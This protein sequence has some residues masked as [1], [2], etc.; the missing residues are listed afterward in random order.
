MS[1]RITAEPLRMPYRPAPV[2][3]ADDGT[4]VAEFP[5]SDGVVGMGYFPEETGLPSGWSWSHAVPRSQP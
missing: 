3:C 2:G 5:W 1:T 4:P